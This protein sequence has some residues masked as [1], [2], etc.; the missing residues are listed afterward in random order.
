[1]KS[2]TGTL[3]FLSFLLFSCVFTQAAQTDLI[4]E[5][6][7][8]LGGQ[9]TE[10][11]RNYVKLLLDRICEK[12]VVQTE[13]LSEK[14][15]SRSNER[16]LVIYIGLPARHDKL[17]QLCKLKGVAVPDDMDPGAEGFALRS[18]CGKN[19]IEVLAVAGDDR[20]VLYAVG[21]ILRQ[22]T[23]H[24]NGIEFPAD[25]NIRTAPAFRMRGTE[26]QQ[27]YKMRDISGVR[28]WDQDI[29]E[30]VELDFVL[31]GAN[32][33]AGGGAGFH[34]RYGLKNLVGANPTGGSGPPEWQAV[35][36]IGRPNFLCPSIPE[37][38]KHILDNFRNYA[39]SLSNCDYV[40][41]HAAD[42]GGCWCEK[43]APFGKTYIEMCEEMS[44]ILL[45]YH[46]D[47][48]VMLTLQEFDNASDQAIFDHINKK[49]CDWLWALCYSPGSNAMVWTSTRRP[50][51]RI[52][53]FHYP[54][55]G[56]I[57]RYVREILHQL[58]SEVNIAFFTDVT[59]WVRSQ[60]GLVQNHVLPDQQ[61]YLPPHWTFMEYHRHP[62]P[63]L[64]KLYA[65]R[66][67][68]ARPRHYYW[69]FHNIMRYGEGDTVYSEGQHDHFNRWMWMRMLWDPHK[70]L[71]DLVNEYCRFWFGPEA[72]PLMAEAISQMEPNLEEPLATN[73][74]IDR[75]YLLVREAGWRIPEC[76]MKSDYLW[77][78][79]MQKASL[80]KYSQLLLRRQM[81]MRDD[82]E[83]LCRGVLETKELDAAIGKGLGLFA[84]DIET[85]EMK[86]LRAE[87]GR[88]GEESGEIFAVR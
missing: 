47:A 55:F 36:P 21:E 29:I 74:G 31:T 49:R 45:E 19:G 81:K 7:I 20:G 3:F 32:T 87:A 43:C 17:K 59:H 15:E 56:P 37:A 13:I 44:K 60:Y 27:G 65:R 57:D 33:I 11:E 58:P 23:Y 78:Q 40:R 50:E 4:E 16:G 85:D 70:S 75:Y 10:I 83:E 28:A 48:K 82:I 25:L 79:H 80:D 66:T 46:P 51:H 18:W 6:K 39:K 76:L 22:I 63:A 77:R 72:A 2:G 62:D 54:A 61:G 1:M 64:F 67:F 12:S 9:A 5:I 30:R 68:F 34:D 71:D 88:L 53:L 24:E 52:D 86:R 26:V 8:V 38:R 42:P 84:A 69:V 73:E 14:E 41:F 35:E